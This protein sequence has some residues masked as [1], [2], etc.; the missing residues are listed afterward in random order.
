MECYK[1][2]GLHSSLHMTMP[3]KVCL[4]NPL[5][6]HRISFV[7]FSWFCAG[8]ITLSFVINNSTTEILDMLSS[9]PELVCLRHYTS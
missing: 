3:S 8:I 1:H 6:N 9:L 4:G 2:H 5:T 7:E